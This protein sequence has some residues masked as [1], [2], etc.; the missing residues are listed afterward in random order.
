MAIPRPLPLTGSIFFDARGQDRALR[1][2]WHHDADLVVLSLWRDNECSGS[3]RLVVEE[4]PA[5]IEML[6]RG[7]QAS[8]A[9]AA[10]REDHSK[11]R[12]V[13]FDHAG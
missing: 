11:R 8:Y 2:T 3:F 9:V 4:V 12:P 6:Q 10:S 13:R 7:L 1:V 5:L